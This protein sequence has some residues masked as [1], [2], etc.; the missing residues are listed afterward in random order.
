M[1]NKIEIFKSPSFG[2]VRAF[3]DDKGEPWFCGNDVA[4]AL[5]YAN[6]RDA[7]TKFCK[8]K[9]VVKRDT[10]T[11]GGLQSM[12]Y[13]NEANM[14]RLVFGS[15]LETAEQF[16]DWVVEEVLPTLRKTGSY[17][18]KSPVDS[19]VYSENFLERCKALT[20][21]LEE[22]EKKKQLAVAKEKEKTMEAHKALSSV[23]DD[24]VCLDRRYRNTV[25]AI[26]EFFKGVC[27]ASVT[28]VAKAISSHNKFGVKISGQELFNFLRTKEL[29]LKKNAPSQKAIE[30]GILVAEFMVV[31]NDKKKWPKLVTKVTPKGIILITEMLLTEIMKQEEEQFEL[32]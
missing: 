5:G 29:V 21:I 26:Q 12:T 30:K 24:Y 4:T 14:Y 16:Q 6:P 17:S 31:G 27:G 3:A 7:I 25:S 13:I 2:S 1:E 18:V 28:D 23:K 32:F 10:P 22:E 20:A 11:S 19:V 15:K 8:E 9:G